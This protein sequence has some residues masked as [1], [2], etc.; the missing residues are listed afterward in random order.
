MVFCLVAGYLFFATAAATCVDHQ[1]ASH[2]HA[3]QAAHHHPLCGETQCSGAAIVTDGL[4][5]PADLPRLCGTVAL[6]T[7][8]PVSYLFLSFAA[9]R[10]PPLSL[11]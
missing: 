6:P 11:V 8:S 5:A 10:A 2:H 9:S 4:S 3:G 7:V 1:P